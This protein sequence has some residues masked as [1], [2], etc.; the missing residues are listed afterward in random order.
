MKELKIFI[1]LTR[2]DRPIGYLLLFWPCSWGLAYAYSLNKNIENFLYYI[3]LFLLGSILMRSAGCIVNDIVDRKLDKRVKR[4]KY[5]PLAANLIS[6]KKAFVYVIILCALAFCILIQFNFLTIMLGLA[7]MT[8]AFSYPFMKR[9]TYWPQLFLG[10]TFNWGII[11]A[12]V[13]LSNYLT[14]DIFI[15]YF[16]AIFWTLGY[17]TIYG[18]Q[19]IVDDEIIGVKSTSIKFKSMLKKFVSIN[20]S[21]TIIILILFFFNNSHSSIF[22]V[23]F[24]AFI[25]TLIYQ[26][27]NFDKR[28]PISCLDSFK[29]NN[30]SGFYMFI[31]FLTLS[32]K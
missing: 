10:L 29:I 16:A 7:S 28:N 3:I 32:F 23:P 20:Y 27:I 30:I 25:L 9:I 14:L 8:L 6:V 1:D 24:T 4:T 13:S 17:D 26:I 12:W 21:I 2:L 5:R 22:L 31:T 15:V 18:A 11:M 19:D